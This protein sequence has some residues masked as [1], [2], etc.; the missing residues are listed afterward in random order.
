VASTSNPRSTTTRC[1]RAWRRRL[2]ALLLALASAVAP[3]AAP[4]ADGGL[5]PLP[6]ANPGLVVDLGVGLWAWPLPCD[7]DGDGDYD[8]LV[9]CPDKPSN[10]VWFFENPGTDTAVDPLP[11]FRPGRRLSP[12][13]HY[14]MPSY[15]EGGMRA[16]AP[17]VE[18]PDFA[19]S[20]TARRSP[21]P[22]AA[23]WYTP[24]G[25]QPKGP[26]VRH[27]QWRLVDYDAD[28]Q[29]DLVCGIEDWSDYGWD[30]GYDAA[31]TWTHGPLHGLVFV[32]AGRPDGSFADPVPV[33][34]AGRPIDV[35]G[36]PS[37]N[38]ADFDGDGDLDLL[39]G[40]FLDGCTYFRNVGTRTEP[41]YAAGVPVRTDD[42]AVLTMEVQ[43]I[44]PVAFDWNKDGHPDLVIG[45]EDGR[46]AFVAHT[47]RTGDDGAPRFRRPV[48]FRQQADTL[49]CGALAT[50]AAAD[51][52]GDGDTDILCGNT[53]GFIELFEN[54]SGPGVVEP[55]WAAPRRLE[56]GGRTL[57]IMAGTN[58]SI[59]GPAEAKWGY[60]T[61]SVADWDGD[62]PLDLVVNSISGDVVWLRNTGTRTAPRFAAP[63]A[64]EVEWNGPPPRLAWGWRTPRDAA[65]LTQWRTTP[66]AFDF[67]G[68]GLVDLAMLD[69]EGYLALFERSRRG[70]RRV[71]ESPRRAFLDEAGRPLRLTAGT[72]GASGRRKLCVTDWDGDG[73]FDLLVNSKNADL[74]RQVKAENGTWRFAN[75]GGLAE[76]NIEGHDVSPAVVDFAGTGRPEFLGGAEDGRLYRLRRQPG[77]AGASTP[78]PAAPP[79]TAPPATAPP[80]PAAPAP[81]SRSAAADGTRSSAVDRP[82]DLR[83]GA[84]AI[85]GRGFVFET[86]PVPSCHASTIC[87]AGPGEFV[88]AWF[89][90]TAEGAADVDIWLA[91]WEN[92]GW[93]QPVQVADGVQPADSLEAGTRYPCWNPVLFRPRGGALQLYYKVGPSP[94]AWWG[95]VRESADGGRTWGPP[96]RLPHGIV[97]PVKNKPVQLADGT[98]V[99]GASEEGIKPAPVWQIHF[100]RSGDGGATWI[101]VPTAQPPENGP[102]AIQPS[103]LVHADG[104][105]QA[106]GRTRG[107]RRLFTTE[108]RD[109]GLSWD[110]VTT[111]DLPNPNSGT[112]AVTLADG[113]HL[114]VYNPS[115][116][117]RSPLAI[118]VSRDGRGWTPVVALEI[119]PDEYSYPAIIQAADGSVRC[120]YTWQRQKI[121]VV[122]IDPA[123]LGGE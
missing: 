19:R 82:I 90:G 81:V 69:H 55:R 50:P 77:A 57:R 107:S 92:G 68:D 29:L 67:T 30:D 6:Y 25:T 78:P 3:P 100:E 22:I 39:C 116:T 118:A 41:K 21:L 13:V 102:A 72:A 10:G 76:R 16:L 83:L 71:L 7:A 11:V 14:V 26:K 96:R 87:E 108:S 104:R 45:D 75:A 99:A 40:S 122:T 97:G 117:A 35:F 18:F 63:A 23:N 9:S 32:L 109:R 84:A 28:G 119:S 8:L 111:L 44:V 62:G 49:K 17:G 85:R 5:E 54:L 2:A 65:L 37:P 112:D 42:G 93:S 98:I 34:A 52:D 79:A 89:G 73:R 115:E 114:L 20:G 80:E 51:L 123:H 38:L 48:P 64:V 36:C 43:M 94:V 1:R 103:I 105:L 46:V 66:V 113:R 61:F 101:R 110:A 106:L 47:G 15:V 27:N 91:R 53:A 56:A 74:L 58:G 121:A 86:P 59:Q 4:A 120:T 24:R 88:V 12:T 33:E 60:T 70:E 31:G 95:L